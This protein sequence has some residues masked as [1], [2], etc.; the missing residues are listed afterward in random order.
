MVGD[1]LQ[2]PRTRRRSFVS[3]RQFSASTAGPGPLA[4]LVDEVLQ[5]GGR[6]GEPIN[7]CDDERVTRAQEL[8]DTATSASLAGVRCSKMSRFEFARAQ[9]AP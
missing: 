8:R 1:G 7:T 5:V 4:K 9:V 3:E 2:R 6:L